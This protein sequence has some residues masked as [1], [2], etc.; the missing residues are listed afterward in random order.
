MTLSNK[1]KAFSVVNLLQLPVEATG[2]GH[3]ASTTPGGLDGYMDIKPQSLFPL[4]HEG[5][6]DGAHSR[7]TLLPPED[8]VNNSL[9]ELDKIKEMWMLLGYDQGK[10]SHQPEIHGTEN[11]LKRGN[12]E[13]YRRHRQLGKVRCHGN[14]KRPRHEDHGDDVCS[15]KKQR[16][17]SSADHGRPDSSQDVACA[18]CFCHGET[19]YCQHPGVLTILDTNG[20]GST[21]LVELCHSDLWSSFHRLGT[22]MIITKSGRR[23]FPVLK[24][25]VSGLARD[26]MYSVRLEFAQPDTR[27]YRYIYNNSR[28]M[29]SGSGDALTSRPCHVNPEGPV[30][31]QALCSQIL[32]FERLKMTN[33]DCIKPGQ[34]SLVSMQKFQ[35]QIVIEEVVPGESRSSAARLEH[36]VINFTQTSFM[37][38]TAYQNQQVQ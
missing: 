37:A 2:P 13:D 3:A 4:K 16:L 1:A 20:S 28:W 26:K 27:K 34:V 10:S 32:S 6:K 5:F 24:L 31:G 25:R 33:T 22:E 19:M 11:L 12:S 23:M 8:A 38:V 35:P 14:E 29:V 21:V 15:S 18:S 30:S 7:A 36:Y 17:V 9:S